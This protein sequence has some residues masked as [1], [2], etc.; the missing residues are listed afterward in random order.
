M[1]KITITTILLL[2]SMLS[3]SQ[4]AK[5]FEKDNIKFEYPTEWVQRDFP[6]YYILVSEPTKEKMSVMTT[7]DVTVVENRN[8]LS[9]YCEE[10]ESQLSNSEQFKDYKIKEKK[11]ITF[12]GMKAIE[13]HC[14]VTISYIPLEWKSIV[15]IKNDKAYKVTTSSMIGEFYLNKEKTERIF[16][17]FEIK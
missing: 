15:F 12:K 5:T 9:M 3:L 11:E 14:S 2:F 10:Y 6:G 1:I 4:E 17:S 7:F 13:Y 16:N 8:N